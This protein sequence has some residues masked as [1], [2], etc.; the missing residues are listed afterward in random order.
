[1]TIN[2]EEFSSLSIVLH[3]VTLEKLIINSSCTTEKGEIILEGCNVSN[4]ENN[5]NI[6]VTR[7]NAI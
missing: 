5:S 4:I 3:H 6:K 7:K 2:A 1:M